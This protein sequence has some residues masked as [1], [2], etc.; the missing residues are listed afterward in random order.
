MASAVRSDNQD[1]HKSPPS[2]AAV[3]LLDQF[4]LDK[5]NLVS[6]IG[7]CFGGISSLSLGAVMVFK[8]RFDVATTDK[9]DENASVKRMLGIFCVLAGVLAVAPTGIMFR[10]QQL[11]A[12]PVTTIVM[13]NYLGNAF[14]YFLMICIMMCSNESGPTEL[15]T[16][17][18]SSWTWLL[19]ATIFNAVENL[20]VYGIL[21][22]QAATA[23]ALLY[24]GPLWALPMAWFFLKE[25][26]SWNNLVTIVVAFVGVC[27]AMAPSEDSMVQIITGSPVGNGLALLSGIGLAARLTTMRFAARH[28]KQAPMILALFFGSLAVALPSL[29]AALARGE[30]LVPVGGSWRFVLAESLCNACYNVAT[31]LAVRFISSEIVALLLVLDAVFSPTLV[32]IIDYEIPSTLTLIGSAM[33]LCAVTTNQLVTAFCACKERCG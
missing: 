11:L 13:W 24:A 9:V 33:M 6:L 7:I 14:F 1:P 30:S 2:V 4:D 20:N 25:D 12:L 3:A 15:M 22:T 31:L 21:T 18:Q 17:A 32:S 8:S 27:L 10:E 16:N 28:C 29:F 26:L 5:F 19:L 23:Y